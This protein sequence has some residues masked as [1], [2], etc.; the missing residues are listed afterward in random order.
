MMAQDLYQSSADVFGS[1]AG[2]HVEEWK[3]KLVE[4]RAIKNQTKA[5]E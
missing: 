5:E 1:G 3:K 2:R 4:S